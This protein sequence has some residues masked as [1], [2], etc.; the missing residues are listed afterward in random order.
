MHPSILP[1]FYY[2]VINLHN[3][4]F[5]GLNTVDVADKQTKHQTKSTHDAIAKKAVLCN[6]TKHVKKKFM[7]NNLK[8]PFPDMEGDRKRVI[9]DWDGGRFAVIYGLKA[10]LFKL[11]HTEGQLPRK[12]FICMKC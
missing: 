4:D 6:N 5:E 9:G 2:F 10:F 3:T 12:R 1:F 7:Q 11:F 8:F